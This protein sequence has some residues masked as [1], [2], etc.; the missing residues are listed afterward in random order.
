M[1]RW[2]YGLGGLIAWTVHFTGLYAIASLDAQ[3]PAPDTA[4]WI[5]VAV[6]LSLV[7][8]MACVILAIVAGRRLRIQVD[9][10]VT[11]MDQLSFLGAILA[12]VAIAWQSLSV[13]IV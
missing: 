5:G 12:L 8:A 3:T 2:S 1:P 13:L 10:V 7:C 11:L 9:E 6:A 4:L